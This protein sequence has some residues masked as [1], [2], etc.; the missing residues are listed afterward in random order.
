MTS[1]Q[2]KINSNSTLCN[3]SSS[4]LEFLNYSLYLY[5][6]QLFLCIN[7]LSLTSCFALIFVEITVRI[8]KSKRLINIRN[9]DF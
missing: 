3:E 1:N 5:Y 2:L 4:S 8:K 9:F 7:D 6:S